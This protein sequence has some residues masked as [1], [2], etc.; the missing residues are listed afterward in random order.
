MGID[1][2]T[3]REFR[4]LLRDFFDAQFDD[5]GEEANAPRFEVIE[6][7]LDQHVGVEEE[8]GELFLFVFF[9][10][11]GGVCEVLE[12]IGPRFGAERV[13][14]EI[15]E[16]GERRPRDV[17]TGYVGRLRRALE[18]APDPRGPSSS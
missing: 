7:F 12:R 15:R 17:R 11:S 2:S 16:F 14:Q 6:Q 4:L 18:S 10:L 8:L 3:I 13:A 9:D 1:A 5:W